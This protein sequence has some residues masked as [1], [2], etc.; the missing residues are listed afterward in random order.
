MRLLEKPTPFKQEGLG[1]LTWDSLNLASSIFTNPNLCSELLT[2]LCLLPIRGISI[3]LSCV[4][5]LVSD[6]KP[7]GIV[8]EERDCWR[9]VSRLNTHLEDFT[10]KSSNST[11]RRRIT[12]GTMSNKTSICPLLCP[13]IASVASSFLAGKLSSVLITSIPVHEYLPSIK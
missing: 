10:S 3:F 1:L 5:S 11:W 12:L 2:A 9:A 13:R 8:Y 6:I 4:I 7:D